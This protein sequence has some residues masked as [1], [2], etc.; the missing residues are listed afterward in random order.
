[1][2]AESVEQSG[3]R[4]EGK[5][6]EKDGV[7]AT[8]HDGVEAVSLDD[9]DEITRKIGDLQ[10]A[11]LNQTDA[12]NVPD[13]GAEKGPTVATTTT[14]HSDSDFLVA[15]STPAGKYIFFIC[16]SSQFLDGHSQQ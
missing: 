16:F 3:A 6:S 2:S 14:V 4:K 10:I 8:S 15:Y 12:Q 1:M 5:P 7:D 11:D 9:E 13:A